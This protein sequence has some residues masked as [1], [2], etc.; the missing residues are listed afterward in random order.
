MANI[1]NP[2]EDETSFLRKLYDCGGE[3]ALQGNIRLLNPE[4]VTAQKCGRRRH[5]TLPAYRNR[6][7]INQSL[8]AKGAAL[9]VSLKEKIS[10]AYT[11]NMS[12]QLDPVDNSMAVRLNRKPTNSWQWEIYCAGKSTP[13]RRSL[14]HFNTM[15]AGTRT[16]K[17]ALKQFLD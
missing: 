1:T 15:G 13:V 11:V 14:V 10:G 6:S 8:V 7:S 9:I 12:R 17:A 16:G 2:T 4:Y 3:L 5:C